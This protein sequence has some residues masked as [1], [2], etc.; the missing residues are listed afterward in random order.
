MII[1]TDDGNDNT[2]T[3]PDA[4]ICINFIEVYR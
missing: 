4:G 3:I 2:V 1:K